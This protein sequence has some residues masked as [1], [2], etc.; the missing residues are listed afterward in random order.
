MQ[1]TT[2]QNSPSQKAASITLTKIISDMIERTYYKVG[3]RFKEGS[4]TLVVV[5][6]KY[7]KPSCAGCFYRTRENC[8]AHGHVC[9]PTFR[10]DGLHVVFKDTVK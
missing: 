10:K 5:A 4:A 2:T 7:N 8:A 9:T 6:Q 1:V 3:D